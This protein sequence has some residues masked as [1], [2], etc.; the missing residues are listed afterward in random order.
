MSLFHHSIA[1]G[2]IMKDDLPEM[3]L[4]QLAALYA[5]MT[6]GDQIRPKNKEEAIEK[7]SAL[8]KKSYGLRKRKARFHLPYMGYVR[9]TWTK[10]KTRR[11]SLIKILSRPGGATIQECSAVTGWDYQNTYNNI[12]LLHTLIGYG[13]EEDESTGKI[14]IHTTDASSSRA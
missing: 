13:V 1:F 7:L 10:I 12:K 4:V 3:S 6:G 8:K 2:K 14:W 11:S 9:N 5:E